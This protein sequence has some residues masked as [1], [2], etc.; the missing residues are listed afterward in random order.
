MSP[1]FRPVLDPDFVPASLWNR[2]YRAAVQECGRGQN[3]AIALERSDGSVSVLRTTVLP[4]EGANVAINHRYVE[5]LV[6]F[7]LWQKGGYR[8]TIAGDSRI[9]DYLRTVYA[10]AGARAFDHALIRE[11]VYKRYVKS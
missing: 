7:L 6:K 9:A 5:R 2:G 3:L 1:K 11:R 8:V 4:H 10:P